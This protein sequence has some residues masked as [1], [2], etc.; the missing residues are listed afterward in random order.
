MTSTPLPIHARA[1]VALTVGVFGAALAVGVL[2]AWDPWVA[3]AACVGLIAIPAAVLNPRLVVHLLLVTVYASAFSV[4]GVTLNRLAA[5]LAAIAILSQLL[6]EPSRLRPSRLTL[7]LVAGY[8]L[9]AFASLAWSVNPGATLNGLAALAISV[10]YMGGFALLVQDSRDVRA[11]FW[12][13]AGCSIALGIWWTANYALGV[14]RYA[15][16]TGDANFVAALQVVS[17]PMVLALASHARTAAGRAGLYAGVAIIAAS[18]VATLSRGELIALLVAVVLIAVSPAHLLFGSRR[19]KA[20]LLLSM[21]GGL[22]LVLAIAWGD[23]SARFMQGLNEPGLAAGRGDLAAAALHGF[24]DHPLLGLGYAGFAP[25]SFELLRTTPN[26]QLPVHLRCLAPR[27]PEYLR[28][29]GTFCT[30]QPVHNAYLESLV[31][32]GFPGALIFVG[33]FGAS[34]FSLIVT[35]RR[36]TAAGEGFIASAAMALTVG[37]AAI[38]VASFELSTETSRAPWMIVG[39]GLALPGL[40]RGLGGP[41]DQPVRPAEPGIYSGQ[42]VRG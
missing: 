35:A 7:G 10:A 42:G 17:L 16:V 34:A 26:V 2:A 18:I 27:A 38:A 6:R 1:D 11:L 21:A 37:M 20:T 3:T 9:L 40:I 25:S 4:G 28:S 22:V 36:A 14:S 8:L 13:A 39:L 12:V 31:E 24:R 33:I 23:V 19:R 29:S 41:S 15:N 5:P 32:L 30:G